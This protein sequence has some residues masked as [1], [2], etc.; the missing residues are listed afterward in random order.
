MYAVICWTKTI[1]GTGTG[2]GID[3]DVLRRMRR[4][5]SKTQ[6]N[7]ALKC[8]DGRAKKNQSLKSNT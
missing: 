8:E 1:T 5:P 7:L 2:T 6:N 4:L 3:T